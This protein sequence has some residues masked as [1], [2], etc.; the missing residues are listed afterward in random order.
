MAK[1]V[2]FL[3]A[4]PLNIFPQTRF[5][6]KVERVSVKTAISYMQSLFNQGYGI[7]NY[8]RHPAT[9]SLINRIFNL[10]LAPNNALY[11]YEHGDVLF[12]V[13]LKKP[14]RGAEVESLTAD[15][16]DIFI[17]ELA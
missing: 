7:A 17:V 13:S 5:Y 10:P 4:L 8:I 16:L 12:V 2:V 3:N 14:V 15:D 6:L 9:V 1:N 11:R